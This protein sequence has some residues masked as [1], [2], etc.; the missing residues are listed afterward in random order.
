MNISAIHT[1]LGRDICLRL[2]LLLWVVEIHYKFGLMVFTE[3]IQLIH[4]M[5]EPLLIL[6]LSGR[7]KLS[8]GRC[9]VM[10]IGAGRFRVRVCSFCVAFCSLWAPRSTESERK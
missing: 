6:T 10:N 2:K 4:G 7:V 8:F 3:F 9:V 5:I 1:I